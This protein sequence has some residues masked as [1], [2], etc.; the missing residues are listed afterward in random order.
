MCTALPAVVPHKKWVRNLEFIYFANV[1]FF[2]D[3]ISMVLLHKG[4]ECKFYKTSSTIQKSTLFSFPRWVSTLTVSLCLSSEW[5]L[6]VSC[7]CMVCIWH[8]HITAHTESCAL[9]LVLAGETWNK[10]LLRGCYSVAGR[11]HVLRSA[12]SQ[13]SHSDFIPWWVAKAGGSKTGTS[14]ESQKR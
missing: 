8:L 2:S 13:C 7:T 1:V 9:Y 11:G 3:P 6:G 5:T 12:R 4:K 14:A 10:R